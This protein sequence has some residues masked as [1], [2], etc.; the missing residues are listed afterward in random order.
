MIYK[1]IWILT[2]GTPVN[3]FNSYQRNPLQPKLDILKKYPKTVNQITKEDWTSH[4]KKILQE[5]FIMAANFI[6]FSCQSNKFSIFLMHVCL[7]LSFDFM[8]Y[9]FVY[10][11]VYRLPQNTLMARKIKKAIGNNQD[12]M[13]I[14]QLCMFANSNVSIW[15]GIILN[16]AKINGNDKIFMLKN[17]GR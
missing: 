10:L 14:C 2:K 11:G 13:N 8:L 17:G 5:F 1:W 15:V 6:N 3:G 12:T 16:S 9:F 7:V 4:K